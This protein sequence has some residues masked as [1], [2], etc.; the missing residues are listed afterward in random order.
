[1]ASQVAVEKYSGGMKDYRTSEGKAVKI[2]FK[3]PLKNTLRD[4]EGSIRSACTY[5]NAMDLVELEANGEFILVN[6]TH[7]RVFK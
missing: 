5:T 3:G 7:N 2:P 1:M 6:E 4:I